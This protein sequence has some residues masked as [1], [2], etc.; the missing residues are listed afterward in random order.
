MIAF[1]PHRPLSPQLRLPTATGQ[2]TAPMDFEQYGQSSQQPRQRRRRAGRRRLNNKAP[3]AARLALD[4]QLRGKVGLLSE[5]LANDLFQQQTLQGKCKL[6][7]TACHAIRV[8]KPVSSEQ[9]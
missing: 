1:L 8:N 2:D 3:I 9:M 4:P 6:S 5:D 7:L